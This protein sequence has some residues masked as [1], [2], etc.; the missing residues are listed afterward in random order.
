MGNALTFTPATYDFQPG[1]T[2]Q[3]T[4]T[5]GATSASGALATPWV[6][7]FTTAVGSTGQGVFVSSTAL[8]QTA[9]PNSVAVDDVNG[10]GNLDIVSASSFTGNVSVH[11]YLTPG[12][13]AASVDVRV[14]LA[15][16][17]VT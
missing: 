6:Q 8:Q 17:D 16:H 12:V 15:P 3:F 2:V 1:E 10:D 9:E 13:Y 4:V 5:R 7:Q 14:G 11:L